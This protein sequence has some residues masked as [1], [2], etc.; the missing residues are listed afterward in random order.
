[1]KKLKLF[2]K[3]LF[4]K[5]SIERFKLLTILLIE[6]IDGLFENGQTEVKLLSIWWDYD[7]K[8]KRTIKVEGERKIF[9]LTTNIKN[10]NYAGNHK[11][12]RRG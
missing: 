6:E 7:C 3:F 8:E 10:E 5:N 11:G 1:M 2:I 4:T 9:N 12:K